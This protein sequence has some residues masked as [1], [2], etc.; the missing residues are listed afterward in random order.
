MPEKHLAAFKGGVGRWLASGLVL[1]YTCNG[2][3]KSH[4]LLIGI[5]H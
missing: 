2:V 3:K 4:I 5:D 1:F